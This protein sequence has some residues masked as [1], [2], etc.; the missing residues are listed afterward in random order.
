MR[1]SFIAI[2]SVLFLFSVTSIRPSLSGESEANAESASSLTEKRIELFKTN[3]EKALAACNELYPSEWGDERIWVRFKPEE[4]YRRIKIRLSKT[5]KLNLELASNLIAWSCMTGKENAKEIVDLMSS[6]EITIRNARATSGYSRKEHAVVSEY[7]PDICLQLLQV[8]K[9]KKVAQ[10][11]LYCFAPGFVR[12]NIRKFAEASKM[13]YPDGVPDGCYFRMVNTMAKWGMI[14]EACEIIRAYSSDSDKLSGMLN[15]IF[16]RAEKLDDAELAALDLDSLAELIPEG[17]RPN[18]FYNIARSLRVRL[19]TSCDSRRDKIRDKVIKYYRKIYPLAEGDRKKQIAAGWASIDTSKTAEFITQFPDMPI[20]SQLLR[21][22]LQ[23]KVG[24]DLLSALIKKGTVTRNDGFCKLLYETLAEPVEFDPEMAGKMFNWAVEFER[25]KYNN[26]RLPQLCS[27]MAGLLPKE[28]KI[29]EAIAAKMAEKI[30]LAPQD[31]EY[32]GIQNIG[33]IL[34]S[35]YAMDENRAKAAA[36]K[37]VENYNKPKPWPFVFVKRIAFCVAMVD[38]ESARVLL[39]GVDL[40]QLRETGRS[41]GPIPLIVRFGLLAELDK[42]VLDRM[43]SRA[44]SFFSS[45]EKENPGPCVTHIIASWSKYFPED[46]FDYLEKNYERSKWFDVYRHIL[47]CYS[48]PPKEKANPELCRLIWENVRDTAIKD[49]QFW[50]RLA[51]LSSNTAPE[52]TILAAEKIP[53]DSPF[54]TGSSYLSLAY[55][56]LKPDKRREMQAE[57]YRKLANVAGGGPKC[58][59]CVARGI[60]RIARECLD[61]EDIALLCSQVYAVMREKKLRASNYFFTHWALFDFDEASRA[62]KEQGPEISKGRLAIF[63][64]ETAKH[65]LNYIS[66][67]EEKAKSQE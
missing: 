8:Q 50:F 5:E 67:L 35:L 2:L 51:A 7:A 18:F 53:L 54:Y 41:V 6:K 29:K 22:A 20:S 27:R 42:T 28:S 58:A 39:D 40:S 48:L 4:A 33:R 26:L 11:L 43:I 55:T 60:Y 56:N 19:Y 31:K 49:S 57:F 61:G 14:A 24:D 16:L 46:A 17:E 38:E 64:K 52:I 59:E 45:L 36:K 30:S 65:G 25:V 12:A 32:P 9:D 37:F 21:A 1:R 10:S 34:P 47:K 63:Y 15:N 44:I 3:I 23:V 13:A 66:R 62:F